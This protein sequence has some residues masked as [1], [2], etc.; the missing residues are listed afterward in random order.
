MNLLT[1]DEKLP[2]VRE[3]ASALQINPMTI[4]KAFSQLEIE[5]VLIR[6]RGVGMLVAE[7]QQKKE[8]SSLIE[9]PLSQFIKIAQD[10]N[11][12]NDEIIS[13]VQQFLS[14]QLNKDK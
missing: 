11:L 8:P 4:S 12:S 9:I 2:S 13:V 6:K 10:E 7:R 3:L 5:G 1:K 14:L